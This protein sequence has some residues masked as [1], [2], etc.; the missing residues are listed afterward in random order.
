MSGQRVGS[1]FE[2]VFTKLIEKYPGDTLCRVEKCLLYRTLQIGQRRKSGLRS[3]L[4]SADFPLTCQRAIDSVKRATH[5][6]CTL[7]VLNP[8]KTESPRAHRKSS[9]EARDGPK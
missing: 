9:D 4:T 7:R 8:G 5:R 6:W 1:G 2:P 3:G